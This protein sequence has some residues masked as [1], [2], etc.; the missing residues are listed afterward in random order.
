MAISMKCWP[1]PHHY[2]P[3]HL[4]GPQKGNSMNL[5]IGDQFLIEAVA[6][7]HNA[8]SLSRR[9]AGSPATCRQD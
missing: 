4:A 3:K 9:L 6:Y 1:A 5:V 7:W 8:E 2:R